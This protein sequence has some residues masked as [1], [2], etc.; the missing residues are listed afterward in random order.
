MSGFNGLMTKLEHD[1]WI[2]NF[3]HG[4][5]ISTCLVPIGDDAGDDDDE[6]S[7]CII[8]K[9]LQLRIYYNIRSLC[10]LAKVLCHG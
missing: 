2:D 7:L 6:Q 4:P 5:G 10:C 3:P 1:D 8:L 9:I